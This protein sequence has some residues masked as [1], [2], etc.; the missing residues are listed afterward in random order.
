MAK[1]R[2]DF[3]RKTIETLAKRVGYICSNPTCQKLTVGSN[4][5]DSKSTLLGIAAHITAASIG[6]PRYDEHLTYEQRISIH[7]GIWLCANCATLIDKDIVRYTKEVLL[8]WKKVAEEKTSKMLSG[9]NEQE[10]KI[11]GKPIIE[12]DITGSSRARYPNGVSDKNPFEM[13]DGRRFYANPQIYHWV[14]SWNFKLIILN[15]SSYPAY[16]LQIENIGQVQLDEFKNLPRKNNLSPHNSIE[17]DLVYTE[18]IECDAKSAD[19][20]LKP[21]FPEKF[22][23][24]VL[25]INYVDEQRSTNFSTLVQFEEGEIIN[26]RIL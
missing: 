7:N 8:E 1:N 5:E 10:I 9:A 14:L 2:D 20:I 17:I 19:S 25:R 24:L 13:I 15:N 12:I 6:G 18:N 4:T 23:D 21:R 26:Q 22:A 11:S 3:K 16:N